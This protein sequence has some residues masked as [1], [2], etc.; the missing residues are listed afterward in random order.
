MMSY[1]G[2]AA[3][4]PKAWPGIQRAASAIAHEGS[5]CSHLCR[6]L[7]GCTGL[8]GV[9]FPGLI[10]QMGRVVGGVGLLEAEG[11]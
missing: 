3:Q 11:E 7:W 5:G 1:A 2:V 4:N 10:S 8:R 9:V 6:A